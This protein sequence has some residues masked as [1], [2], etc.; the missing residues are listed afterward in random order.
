MTDTEEL[1]KYF[2]AEKPT[3]PPNEFI[4]YPEY[5]GYKFNYTDEELEAWIDKLLEA[6]NDA[7]EKCK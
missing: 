3:E 7:R 6:K 2:G 5:I 4:P 1:L